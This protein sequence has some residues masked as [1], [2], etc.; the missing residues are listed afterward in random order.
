[1]EGPTVQTAPLWDPNGGT[2]TC[3]VIIDETGKISD[4]QSGA[5]LCEA[6]PWVSF[7]ISPRSR[8]GTP[9]K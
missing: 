2:V 8:A 3:K 6:V 9:S 4:L 1:M 5:Q 7:V